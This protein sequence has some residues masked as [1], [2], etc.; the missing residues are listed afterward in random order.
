MSGRPVK[1]EPFLQFLSGPR[2]VVQAL[3]GRREDITA[4]SNVTD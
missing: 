3:Q 4:V 1:V 2:S